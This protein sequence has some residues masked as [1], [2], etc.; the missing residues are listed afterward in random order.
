MNKEIEGL[1]ERKLAHG[2]DVRFLSHQPAFAAS[3][4]HR[5]TLAQCGKTNGSQKWLR[6][7]PHNVGQDVVGLICLIFVLN[8]QQDASMLEKGHVWLILKMCGIFE[9]EK[10]RKK[11]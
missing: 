4:K 3:F 5:N 9:L 11:L 1:K 7:H 8:S 10:R 6:H 2:K